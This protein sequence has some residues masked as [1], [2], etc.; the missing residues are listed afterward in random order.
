MS[1]QPQPYEQAHPQQTRSGTNGNAVASLVLGIVGLTGI[2]LIASVLALY[3]GYKARREM[4]QTRQE[5][6]S[7]ATAGIV[8][9]WIGVGIAAVIIVLVVLAIAVGFAVRGG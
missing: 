3:F 1:Q 7:F 8:L 4:L 6:D 5:G 9:G 2:P